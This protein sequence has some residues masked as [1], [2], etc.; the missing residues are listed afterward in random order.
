[1][2]MILCSVYRHFYKAFLKETLRVFVFFFAFS[3]AVDE[4][5]SL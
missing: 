1:M 2:K 3:R 5:D 4:Y